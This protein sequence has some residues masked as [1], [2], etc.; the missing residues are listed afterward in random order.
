MLRLKKRLQ[1]LDYPVLPTFRISA[2]DAQ[3]ADARWVDSFMSW[4]RQQVCQTRTN[5]PQGQTV[6]ARAGVSGEASAQ[7]EKS[8]GETRATSV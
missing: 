5:M 8:E 6:K 4:C 1:E 7:E 2:A 3:E